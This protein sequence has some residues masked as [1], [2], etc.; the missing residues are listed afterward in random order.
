MWCRG[1]RLVHRGVCWMVRSSA[2]LRAESGDPVDEVYEQGGPGRESGDGESGFHVRLLR[3]VWARYPGP[4][5]MV[6]I[7]VSVHR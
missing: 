7:T 2:F 1:G 5:R 6:P 4:T 3:M